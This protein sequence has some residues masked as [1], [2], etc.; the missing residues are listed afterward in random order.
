MT[1]QPGPAKHRVQITSFGVL[2]GPAPERLFPGVAPVEVDVTTALRNPHDDPAMRYR[3]GLDADVYE[4]IMAT[5]GATG[6]LDGALAELLARFDAGQEVVEV[7]SYCRGGRHRSVALA[8]AL[9]AALIER[10]VDVDTVHRDVAKPVIQP[11]P[12]TTKED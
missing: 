3:T 9:G 1:D 6:I 5:P 7:L 11:V 10:G 8:R 12:A 4:H 2:H